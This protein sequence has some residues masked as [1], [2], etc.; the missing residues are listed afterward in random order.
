MFFISLF[1]L[2][3]FSCHSSIFTVNAACVIIGTFYVRHT[4]YQRQLMLTQITTNNN[5][6]STTMELDLK[7]SALE[8]FFKCFSLVDN[9]KT[10]VS[11]NLGRESIA[12]IH[13]MR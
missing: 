6:S 11:Q 1:F 7:P 5:E 2:E 4:S 8:K 9:W 3:L 10:I 13:G 12:V